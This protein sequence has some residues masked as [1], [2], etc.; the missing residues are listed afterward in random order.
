MNKILVSHRI[1]TSI[2]KEL[3]LEKLESSQKTNMGL[4]FVH[5][6]IFYAVDLTEAILYIP[7]IAAKQIPDEES[8]PTL[9]VLQKVLQAYQPDVLIAGNNAVPGLAICAW[10]T[11]V[12]SSKDLLVIRR[13]VDTRAI[14]KA[15]AAEQRVNVGNLPG[16]NSPFVAQHMLK[17]LKL[18][19]AQPNSKIAIIGVGNIGKNIANRAINLG[20]DVHLFS[21]SLQNPNLRTSILEQRGIN[22][23]QV[24]CASSRE[25]ALVGA[26][27]LAIA[28]PWENPQGQLNA[29]MISPQHLEILSVN[30]RIASAS[31]PKIFA[32]QALAF[33]NQKISQGELYVRIDTAQRLA[34]EA[35]Q[36]Y[37]HLETAYNEAFAAPECQRALDYAWLDQARTFLQKKSAVAV[38][39]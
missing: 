28:I 18:E 11:A 14:D 8:D 31:P 2:V 27:Y 19:Q 37:P 22:P 39:V 25:E 13:G 10:R 12:G 17:Y 34:E 7:S 38:S 15:A 33:L 5:D 4:G 30:A 23:H 9:I 1:H 3:G 32:P 24:T 26:E 29:G 36:A 35:K 6:D 16:I 20:L 21:L